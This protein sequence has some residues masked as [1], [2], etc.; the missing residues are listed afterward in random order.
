MKKYDVYHYREN[1]LRKGQIV[2][3]EKGE[4]DDDEI[5]GDLQ[6]ICDGTP[7]EHVQQ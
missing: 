2:Y 7:E 3:Y 5:S 6:F 1:C 4:I